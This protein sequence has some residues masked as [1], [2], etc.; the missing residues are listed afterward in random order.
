MMPQRSPHEW[1]NSHRSSAPSVSLAAR[2]KKTN[3]APYCARGLNMKAIKSVY[4]L[5]L[6]GVPLFLQGVPP[7]YSRFGGTDC[8]RSCWLLY[9]MRRL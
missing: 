3:A 8:F 5:A 4:A 2:A 6:E 1:A 9:R 7:R